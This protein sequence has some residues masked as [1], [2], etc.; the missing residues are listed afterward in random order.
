[1]PYDQSTFG[2]LLAGVQGVGYP[3]L[4]TRPKVGGLGVSRGGGIKGLMPA[5]IIVHDNDADFELNRQVVVRAWSKNP[6]IENHVSCTPFRL[7][8]NAGDV[9][10][11]LNYSCGG[12]CQTPQSIPGIASIRNSIGAIQR[13]CDDT[14]VPPSACNVRYVYDSSDYTTFLRNKA[15]NKNYNDLSFGGG[16]NASQTTISAMRRF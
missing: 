7:K 9:F 10:T 12:P 5:P 14:R 13:I 15:Y 8:M 11:R 6:V 4:V 2:S 1:M 3:I 16:N